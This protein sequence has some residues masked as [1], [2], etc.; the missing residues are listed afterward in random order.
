MIAAHFNI[1]LYPHS[2]ALVTT[3]IEL[4][5]KNLSGQ[6]DK[7]LI[8]KQALPHISLSQFVCQPELA[9]EVW[10]AIEDYVR[11]PLSLQFSHIYIRAGVGSLHTGK[12]WVGLSVVP[13]QSL[14][15]LQKSVYD[16]L[17]QMDID[18]PT[19]PANYFPHLTFGR[20]SDTCKITI[21][22]MP[23]A[24]FWKASYPFD[25]SLGRSNEIGVYS[26]RLY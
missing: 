23:K 5:E 6:T 20:L 21:S 14:I 8:G 11:E 13:N 26:E 12:I 25:V 22:K 2:L 19:K 10:S 24:G 1:A 15:D 3:L 18:S 7:Y 17:Q 16:R 9:K 4:A